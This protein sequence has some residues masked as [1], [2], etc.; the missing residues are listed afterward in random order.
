MNVNRKEH[1]PNDLT[2]T[3]IIISQIETHEYD[4]YFYNE[5]DGAYIKFHSLLQLLKKLDNLFDRCNFPEVTHEYR[6]F[7]EP[8]EDKKR[9]G[10]EHIMRKN[11]NQSD[12]SVKNATFLL[13]VKFRRNASWQGQ[14]Q[15]VDKNMKK[16]FRSTLELIRLIDNA[17]EQTED[18]ITWEESPKDNE[19]T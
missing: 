1:I 10:K 9:M 6:K 18:I 16:N 15:W 12:E 13:Q 14:I 2:V 4:G 7:S 5:Y 17:I 19:Q 11:E 3:K 8:K